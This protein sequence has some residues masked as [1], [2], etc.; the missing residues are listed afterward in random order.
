MMEKIRNDSKKKSTRCKKELKNTL[1]YKG[2]F[3]YLK[4]SDFASTS[5][6]GLLRLFLLRVAGGLIV[7]INNCPTTARK[8]D[9]MT[10]KKGQNRFN[11]VEDNLAKNITSNG[12][13]VSLL[14]R[15]R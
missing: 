14:M 13:H 7:I 6:S 8:L 11:N 2:L 15:L 9:T 5:S 12:S 4:I 1:K 3:T 10:F